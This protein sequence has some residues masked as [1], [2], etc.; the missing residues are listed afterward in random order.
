M[1]TVTLATSVDYATMIHEFAGRA[2]RVAGE[3][4][5]SGADLEAARSHVART[6]DESARREE[7]VIGE[8]LSKALPRGITLKQLGSE[9]DG[10]VVTTRT[11]LE[12]VEVNLFPE[13]V[14]G[15]VEGQPPLKPFSGFSVKK[16]R[17]A[18]VLSGRAPEIA[19]GS[20]ALELS[21]TTVKPVLS[22]N[23]SKQVGDTLTW[24]GSGF[25]VRVVFPS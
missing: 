9:R 11:T 4:P 18:W 2:R 16:E 5:P 21:L 19:S 24:T 8:Q 7:K 22:H 13:V 6:L 10:L 23:A 25:E 20:G 14:L 1:L 12:L 15:T 3:P 17:G